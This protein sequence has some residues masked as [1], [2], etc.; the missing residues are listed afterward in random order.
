MPSDSVFL[1]FSKAFDSIL[2]EETLYLLWLMGIT[3]PPWM[4]LK[5]CLLGRHHYVEVDGA[6][7]TLLQVKSG[8][9]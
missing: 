3:G 9:P 4:W 7:S 8:V 2:H 6:S 1:Y 5:D